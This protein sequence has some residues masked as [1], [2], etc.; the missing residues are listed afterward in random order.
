MKLGYYVTTSV[1]RRRRPD[2]KGYSVYYETKLE[3]EVNRLCLTS[4]ET[5]MMLS[6]GL[7]QTTYLISERLFKQIQEMIEERSKGDAS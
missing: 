7:L 5:K 6:T 1:R 4:D 3:K 2:G